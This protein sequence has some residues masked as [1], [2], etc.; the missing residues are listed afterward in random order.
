VARTRQ[1]SGPRLLSYWEAPDGAGQ[2]IGCVATTY[3]F[4]APFFE[5]HCLGRFAAM[6]SDPNEDARAY[7]IEREE[8]LSQLFACV[9]VD[10]A[11]VTSTRSLRW[12]LCPVSVPRGGIMHAKVSLLVWR[13]QVRVIIASA[14]LTEPGYRKNFE[15]AALLDFTRE[16]DIPLDLLREVLAFLESVLGYAVG[17]E[18]SERGAKAGLRQFLQRVRKHVSGWSDAGWGSSEARAEFLP[19]LPGK[20]SLFEQLVEK[21]WAGP[22]P[23]EVHVMSPF[24]DQGDSV[25]RTLEPLYE[26]MGKRGDRSIEFFVSGRRLPSGVYELDCPQSLRESKRA[27]IEHQFNLIH[28]TVDEG[29]LKD[30]H[31][32]LHAKS[33]WLRRED[34]AVCTVGSSNFTAQGTGVRGGPTNIEANLGYVMLLPTANRFWNQVAESWPDDFELDFE[35]HKLAFVADPADRTPDAAES[36]VLPAGF[37][38]AL[39]DPR[40]EGSNLLLSIGAEAP[41]GFRVESVTGLPVLSHREWRD[42]GEPEHVRR[43]W[44]EVRPPSG[45]IV[46]WADAQGA[47]RR[48]VWVVNVT[49]PDRLAP[50]SELANL[51]L[52]ELLEVLTSAKPLHVAMVSILRKRELRPSAV[53]GAALLLDPHRKVDTRNFLLQRVRYVSRALEGMRERLERPAFTEDAL[54]WRLHGPVGPMALAQRLVESEGQSASFMIAEVALTVR[55]ADLRELESILGRATVR[56]AISAVIEQL[57]RFAR[58]RPAPPNLSRY[59]QDCFIEVGR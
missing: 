32:D 9:L 53:Q 47:D 52:E 16:G 21:T 25:Q 30:L 33:I 2:P 49:D 51:T 27:G 19:V 44:R 59:V 48:A 36:D 8:K 46:H 31:R 39:F 13:H 23:S 4:D 40:P 7:L 55:Q 38:E 43:D 18:G 58:E 15:Q 34:R 54:R 1:Q 35:K 3:T 41:E 26:L 17:D 56:E 12:G 29:D 22:G 14:N 11:H 6:D 50:P 57:E 42:E 10:R 28:S 45:L 24:F 5:E 37:G 20:P